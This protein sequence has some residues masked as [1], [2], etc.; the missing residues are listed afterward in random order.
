MGFAPGDTIVHPRH[1]VGTVQDAAPRGSGDSATTYLTL[2]FELKSLTIM[3]PLDSVDE[4]GIR[5][6]ST[7]Q[8]ADAILALLEEESDVPEAWSERNAFTTSRVQSTDLAQ[9]AMVIRD[10]TRHAQRIE[11]PLSAAENSTLEACLDQVSLELSLS[12]GL[13]QEDTRA[14]ILDRVGEPA[15]ANAEDA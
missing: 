13:S 2:F 6:P 7:K 4:V 9:A 5:H 11:K 15:P 14:L 1:G 10:L 12:L 8:E 3:V